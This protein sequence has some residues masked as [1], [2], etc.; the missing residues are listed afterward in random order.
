MSTRLMT[1]NDYKFIPCQNK[2]RTLRL[3][4]QPKPNL[5]QRPKQKENDMKINQH[6]VANPNRE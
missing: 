3:E 2:S 1:I 5:R 4:S 6:Q